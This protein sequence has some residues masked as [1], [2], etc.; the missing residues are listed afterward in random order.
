MYRW[1]GEG[2]E[3]VYVCC[4]DEKEKEKRTRVRVTGEREKRGIGLCDG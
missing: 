4:V 3:C 2:E 1:D